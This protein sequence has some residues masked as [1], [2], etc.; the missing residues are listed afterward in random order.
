MT[1]MNTLGIKSLEQYAEQHTKSI[2]PLL[3]ELKQVT[4]DHTDAPQMMVG[5]LEGKFLQLI[6][7]LSNAK[8]VL[9]IGT[10][11]GYSTLCMAD[12]VGPNGHVMTI[13]INA[14]TSRIAQEFMSRAGFQDRVTFIIGDALEVIDDLNGD[15]DLVFI[16]ADKI[17]YDSYYEKLLPR[18][19]PSGFLIF[20]NM[21]WSGR[22]LHPQTADDHAL[23]ELN[24]K[25][26]QD[27][28]VENFLIPLRD[29]IQV[30]Q[31]L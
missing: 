13:D 3:A 4:I 16:D 21:L 28:R 6:C 5:N 26:T 27:P 18:V 17:R 15:I 14:D 7:A 8:S 29:G 24:K 25:L 1:E 30:V 9:E 2:H 22:V 12:A 19:K 23:N 20:D 11:T 10:F 31:K